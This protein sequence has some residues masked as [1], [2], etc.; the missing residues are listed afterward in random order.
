MRQKH[1]E[2]IPRHVL[3]AIQKHLTNNDFQDALN[4]LWSAGSSPDQATSLW[5]RYSEIKETDRKGQFTYDQKSAEYS[6]LAEDILATCCAPARLESPKTTEHYGAGL[7]LDIVSGRLKINLTGPAASKYTD[8]IQAFCDEYFIS[9][10]APGP[11]LFGG[12]NKS[13]ACLDSWLASEVAPSRFVLA[14][15]G[16]RGKSALLVHWIE[17]LSA[18]RHIGGA[19]DQWRLV[20][21][22]ITMR[23]NTTFPRVFY[24]AVAA[25]LA[26]ILGATL[27][28]PQTDHAAR[29]ED[30]CRSLLVL[31]SHRKIRILLVIDGADEALGGHFSGRWFPRNIGSNLRILVAARLEAGDQDAQDWVKRLGWEDS[32]VRTQPW[33]LP[34]LDLQGVED[35]LRN[36]GTPV[37]ALATR[38]EIKQK[39]HEL[40]QGEPLLLKF[41]IEDLRQE[42]EKTDRLRVEDLDQMNPGWKGY[43][44][45]WL[46]RQREVWEA[47]GK[48]QAEL[49]RID[50]FLGTLACSYGPLTANDLRE[51]AQTRGITLG[52]RVQDALTPIRRFVIGVGN[53]SPRETVGYVLTHTKLASFCVRNTS[54]SSRYRTHETHLLRGV[55]QSST[56]STIADCNQIEFPRTCSDTSGSTSK[57]WLTTLKRVGSQRHGGS[58]QALFSR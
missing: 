9:E 6:K 33:D 24:E 3:S 17:R 48:Q 19:D 34:E 37:E 25:Q 58:K 47:E 16:G 32:D 20:F 43:F 31:A 53:S 4:V 21:V 50:W 15:P 1:R 54:T 12:R 39:L 57:I 41:Y 23:V 14:G 29:Y 52:F 55:V 8:N 11:V 44:E 26:D 22:P 51:L 5:R 10:T 49:K 56:D 38:S 7:T 36:A 30:R 28:H 45:D 2:S 18:L 40:T 46:R 13:L 42:T 27:D 35:L